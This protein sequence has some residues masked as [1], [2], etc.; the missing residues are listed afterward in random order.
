MLTDEGDILNYIGVK[1]NKNLDGAFKLS[2]SFLVEKIIYHVWLTVS[3]ILKSRET[4]AGKPL[5]NKG[6]SNQER[7]GVCNYRTAVGVLSYLQGST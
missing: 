2:Q 7:K 5:L 3:I 1:I 6:K 4:P